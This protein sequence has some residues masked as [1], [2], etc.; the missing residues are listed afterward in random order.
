MYKD[1]GEEML[2][3]K[4]CMNEGALTLDI[5]SV[6]GSSRAPGTGRLKVRTPSVSGLLA[7]VTLGPVSS[8]NALVEQPSD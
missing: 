6:H 1:K 7:H 2:T 4:A 3:L 5:G 8:C